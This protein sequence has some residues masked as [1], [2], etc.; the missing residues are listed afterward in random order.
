MSH[1]VLLGFQI[2]SVVFVR[3]DDDGHVLH[4]LQ[5]VALQSYTLDG[6]VRDEANFAHAQCTQDLSAH[7]VV[8]FVGLEAEVDVGVHS[9]V[10]LFLE[11]VSRNFVH[12]ADAAPLLV[13]V[14][15]DTLALV[16][17]EFHGLVQL[18][19]AVA[20]PAAEDVARHTAGVHAHQYG[21]VF[22]PLAFEQGHVLQSVALLAEGHDAEVAVLGG[23][24]G[25]HTLLHQRLALQS[26]GDEVLDGDDVQS[27]ALGHLLQLW[28][29]RHGAVLVQYFDECR[30][31]LQSG[32]S[33]QVD[34]RLGVSGPPQHALVL[35]VEGVDV[36]GAPEVRRLAVGV[37]QC[38]DGRSAVVG[39]DAC[40]ATFQQVHGDGERCAQHRRVLLHLVGQLQFACTTDGDGCAEHAAPVLQHEVHLLRCDGFGGSDEVALVLAVFVVHNDDEFALSEVL[41]GQFYV[42][43]FVFHISFSILLSMRSMMIW[44]CLRMTAMSWR[45]RT[46]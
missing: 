33:C 46:R 25:L 40:S 6:V 4:N 44:V 45:R 7:T 16:F 11:F 34:G 8:P 13:E 30:R 17:D 29:A 23:H 18:F 20:S 22:A 5:S 1:A 31:R 26:V 14:D 9:I 21:F 41:D 36:A 35:G 12:Q 42:L 3:F 10:A 19:A 24:V 39:A 38:T 28:H 37:G 15:Y 32:Q 43:E 27:V 2:A